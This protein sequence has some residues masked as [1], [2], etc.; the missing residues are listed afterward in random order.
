MKN[1]NKIVVLSL[2]PSIVLTACSTPKIVR[3]ARYEKAKQ[4]YQTQINPQPQQAYEM[5]IDMSNAPKDLQLTKATGRYTSTCSKKTG[6]THALGEVG[7]RPR[8]ELTLKVSEPQPRHYKVIFY[9]DYFAKADYFHDGRLCDWKDRH[10]DLSFA[11]TEHKTGKVWSM[12]PRLATKEHPFDQNNQSHINYYMNIRDYEKPYT[13][14]RTRVG[15]ILDEDAP[16]VEGAENN[17]NYIKVKVTVT[18]KF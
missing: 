18:K 9:D 12:S 6:A 15:Y 8:E 7:Y 11:P 14:E 16:L 4:M 10:I 13:D 17:K 3:E 2:L 5:D 1:L